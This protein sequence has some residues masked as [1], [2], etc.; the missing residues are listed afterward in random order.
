M[1][2]WENAGSKM[3]KMAKDIRAL[4]RESCERIETVYEMKVIKDLLK[5]KPKS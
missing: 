1:E 4:M 2:T 3:P 5:K